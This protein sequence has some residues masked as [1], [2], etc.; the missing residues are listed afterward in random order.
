MN[1]GVLSVVLHFIITL[2]ILG[3][4]LFTL[5]K[6]GQPDETMKSLLFLIGGYWFGVLGD[7]ITGKKPPNP[8]SDG[9]GG[10]TA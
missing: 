4:Y 7:K 10:A 2:A 6:T 8:P 5:V 3:G 9:Q 1:M